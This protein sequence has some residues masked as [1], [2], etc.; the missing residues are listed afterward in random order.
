MALFPSA[1]FKLLTV[2]ETAVMVT[3]PLPLLRPVKPTSLVATPVSAEL[4]VA[5]NEHTFDDAVPLF[6]KPSTDEI[7]IPSAIN[8]QESQQPHVRRAAVS[9]AAAAG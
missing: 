7:T 3:N 5:R 1:T 8:T 2:D 9:V 4:G 6:S